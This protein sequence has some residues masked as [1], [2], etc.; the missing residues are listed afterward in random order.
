MGNVE[1]ARW[2]KLK[3]HMMQD[4]NHETNCRRLPVGINTRRK[5][6]F[7]NCKTCLKTKQAQ[8]RN[9]LAK[10]FPMEGLK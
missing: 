8:D 3:I 2:A 6:E 1:D 4:G 7:V 10:F 5:W 9:I